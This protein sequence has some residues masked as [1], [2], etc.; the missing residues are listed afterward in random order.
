MLDATLTTAKMS[1]E[2]GVGIDF[3]GVSQYQEQLILAALELSGGRQNRA[4]ELLKYADKYPL[5]KNEAVEYQVII[6][7]FRDLRRQSTTSSLT[8]RES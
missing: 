8:T 7:R 1:L 3:Y 5:H 2:P 4:A 6:S